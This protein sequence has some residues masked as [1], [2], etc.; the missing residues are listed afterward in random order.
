MLAPAA[1]YRSALEG[2]ADGYRAA[3]PGLA[4]SLAP[5]TRPERVW[6]AAFQT[7]ALALLSGLAHGVHAM[8]PQFPQVVGASA[9]LGRAGAAGDLF[10]AS[11]FLR[12]ARQADEDVLA[13]RN[14][15]L[16]A[17]HGFSLQ[18]SGYPGWPGDRENPLARLLDRVWRGQTGGALDITAVHVGL[19][20]AVLRAK[21]P[22]LTMATAG[23]DILDAHSVDERAPWTPSP[24]TPSCWP[25]CW[26][27]CDDQTSG[28][29]PRAPG[30]KRVRTAL[31]SAPFSRRPQ[32]AVSSSSASA[33]PSVS[34]EQQKRP[35]WS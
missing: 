31:P 23:P 12:A 20:P 10:Q 26:R 34:P 24:T 14:A 9:N 6:T 18:V 3:D 4:V 30:R 8:D 22:W 32:A 33:S 29:P 17:A 19:E 35:V 25:A 1:P 7:H 16:G 28:A 15:A 11:A 2:A 21:A 13:A 27:P 5:A